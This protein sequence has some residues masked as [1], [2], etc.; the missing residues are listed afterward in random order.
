[1]HSP[2][3]ISL[4]K[5]A[6]FFVGA[7]PNK[8]QKRNLGSA[9]LILRREGQIVQCNAAAARLFGGEPGDLEGGDIAS[10]IPNLLPTGS[11]SSYG[12]R[13]LAY[14]DAQ[15]KWQ[16]FQA[17]DVDG[18][19]I[20]IEINLLRINARGESYLLLNLRSSFLD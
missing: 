7:L 17:F 11:S 3:S 5:R 1:M 2:Q 15:S 12:L 6:D 4:P 8:G 19:L 9:L 20:N 16:N 13:Y 18:L 14:F 10:F